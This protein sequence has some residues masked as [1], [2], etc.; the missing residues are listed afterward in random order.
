V[1]SGASVARGGSISRPIEPSGEGRVGLPLIAVLLRHE[2]E[3][4]APSLLGERIENADGER[5]MQ[6]GQQLCRVLVALAF[7]DFQGLV[8]AA[9]HALAVE[10]GDVSS[11]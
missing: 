6:E 4:A 1:A 5:R 8:D 7:E 10:L 3:E 2:A 11:R 9:L